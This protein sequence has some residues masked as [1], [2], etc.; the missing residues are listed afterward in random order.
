MNRLI[1]VLVILLFFE[2]G[3]LLLIAPWWTSFWRQNYFLERYPELVPVVLN[4]F[5]RGAVSGLGVLNI[6]IAA[7]ALRGRSQ[8]VARD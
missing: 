1:R 7:S 4:P 3:V 6:L 5:V 2:I 8:S